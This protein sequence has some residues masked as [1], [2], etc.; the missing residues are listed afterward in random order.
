MAAAKLSQTFGS[1]IDIQAPDRPRFNGEWSEMPLS[2]LAA[3]TMGQSPPSQFY[4][5]S[6]EGLPLIQGKADIEGRQTNPQKWTTKVTRS[7]RTG[8]LLLTVRAPVGFV[9]IATT[10]GCLGRGVCA[11]KTFGDSALLFYALLQSQD[12]WKTLE[13][14]STFTAVNSKEV[15]NFK[16]RVPNDQSEQR[17]IAGVLS[18]VDTLLKTMKELIAKKQ[19][20]KRATMQRLLTG[21]TRLPGF[22]GEWKATTIGDLATIRNQ[23][24]FPSNVQFDT[25]CVELDHIERNTGRL[26]VKSTAQ[27]STS[28]KYRFFAGDVLFGRLRSYLR[29]FWYADTDGICTTEMWP[30]IVKTRQVYSEFLYAIVQTDRFIATASLSYGTHMPRADWGVIR[31]FDVKLPPLDEQTA[32]TVVLADIDAE[33]TA[34]LRRRDKTRAIKYGV[35]QQLL[36]GRVRLVKSLPVAEQGVETTPSAQ[37]VY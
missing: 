1:I 13:H 4:N 30:L 34:L 35:M 5:Q 33:I 16:V 18:D 29:K 7:C 12:G 11:L 25:P 21:K 32:I 19:A 27:T 28:S 20:I 14:G 6:R 22:T 36:T 37:K 24:V 26:L 3:V 2:E 31:D 10:S 8:D 17:A 15:S 23:K 9:A